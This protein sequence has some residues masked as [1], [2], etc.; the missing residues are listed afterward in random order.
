MWDV[1]AQKQEIV[2]RFAGDEENLQ[3]QNSRGETSSQV[4]YLLRH[5]AEINLTARCTINRPPPSLLVSHAAVEVPVDSLLY[6]IMAAISKDHV[7]RNI[8]KCLYISLFER[9]V[10][11]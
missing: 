7:S 5:Q 10:F 9:E 3:D 11:W 2:T 6:P 4:G 1:K 8:C